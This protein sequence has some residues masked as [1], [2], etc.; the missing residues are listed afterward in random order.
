MSELW[1][2]EGD[3]NT[4]GG[5]GL[6]PSNPKTVFVEGKNV[7]EVSD[8]AFP[9]SFCPIP[10]HCNPASISGSS[11]VFVY[12][13]PVHRHGDNRICG[14]TTIVSGQSTVFVGG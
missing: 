13:N 2:V 8:P 11:T 10:P 14:A 9:D 7:I 12:G 6:I 3:P 4:H 1:A 5:G